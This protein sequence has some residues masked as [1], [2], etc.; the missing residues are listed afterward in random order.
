M[1]RHAPGNMLTRYCIRGACR[2][3][4]TARHNCAAVNLLH[5]RAKLV[6]VWR[7]L[8]LCTYPAFLGRA[9]F[10]PSR[11]G[12]VCAAIYPRS[13]QNSTGSIGTHTNLHKFVAN[14]RSVAGRAWPLY[15]QQISLTSRPASCAYNN[16][17]RIQHQSS[18]AEPTSRRRRNSTLSIVLVVRSGMNK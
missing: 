9:V 16:R 2:F 12:T 18:E 15:L 17:R 6:E 3:P 7:V 1:A 8:I 14:F 13:Q 10:R 11:F 5:R 4:A